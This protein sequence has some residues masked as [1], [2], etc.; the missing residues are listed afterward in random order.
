MLYD[1]CVTNTKKRFYY[2]NLLA[3][4]IVI[5]LMIT[6]YRAK[7]LIFI[8][9]YISLFLFIKRRTLSFR[10]FII[11]CFIIISFIVV[12]GAYRR[13]SIDATSIITETGIAVAARPAMF[14]MITRNFNESK[15]FYGTRY[16]YDLKKL[17]PGSQTGANIDLKYEIF[18]NADKMP[19]LAGVTPSI[20]GEAYMNFGPTSIFWIMF[21]LGV[22]IGLVYKHM[23]RKPSFMLCIFYFTL[24]F[25]MTGAVQSGVGTVMVHLIYKWIWIL[26]IGFFYEKRVYFNSIEDKIL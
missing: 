9:E 14:E 17:L 10:W 1:A 18:S 16:F 12:I 19:E 15:Y 11:F 5:F 3:I 21:I 25:G 26:I 2:S 20:I 8:G 24:V 22:F 4:I 7:T 13:G 6:G 23:K